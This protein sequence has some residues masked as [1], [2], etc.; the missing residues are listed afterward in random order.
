MECARRLRRFTMPPSSRKRYASMAKL[1][2]VDA[3]VGTFLILGTNSR[4]SASIDASRSPSP[5]TRT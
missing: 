3:A 5:S 2:L 4:R 1:A